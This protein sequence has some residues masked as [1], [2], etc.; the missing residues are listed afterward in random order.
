[1]IKIRKVLFIIKSLILVCVF[2]MSCQSAK[3][4]TPQYGVTLKLVLIGYFSFFSYKDESNKFQNNTTDHKT[5]SKAFGN[6]PGTEMF[7]KIWKHNQ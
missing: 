4:Q 7:D 3:L 6:M 2:L 5:Y 1:M